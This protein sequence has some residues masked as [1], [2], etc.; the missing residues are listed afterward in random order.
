MRKESKAVYKQVFK[1]YGNVKGM[2]LGVFTKIFENIVAKALVP[3]LFSKIIVLTIN[4]EFIV[5]NN[6]FKTAIALLISSA[7]LG[8]VGNFTFVKSSDRRYRSIV[9]AFHSKML[10]K[11]L[12]F[13]NNIG[14]GKLSSFFR[15]HLDGSIKAA[16]LLRGEILSTLS[17]LLLPTIVFLFYD[18]AI[19]FIFLIVALCD[20]V[21]TNYIASKVKKL[22]KEALVVY[23]D[24][25]SEVNDQINNIE[26][27][28]SSG[29][30][31]DFQSK[32]GILAH[33]EEVL[34]SKRHS[35]E[36]VGEAIKAI[37]ISSALLLILYIIITQPHFSSLEASEMSVLSIIFL[38]QFNISALNFPDLYKI[39]HECIDR[40]YFTL[41]IL[42]KKWEDEFEG[43]KNFPFKAD[44]LFNNVSFNYSLENGDVE[45]FKELSVHIE[46][47]EK[48]A[49]VGKSGSGK[50][51]FA[52]LL[53]RF[54]T[55]DK[56]SILIGNSKIENL[57]IQSLRKSISYV[58]AHPILLNRTIKENLLL[59]N[60]EATE[61]DVITACK[62]SKAYDFIIEL[63]DGFSTV[64]GKNGGRLSSGQRQRISIARALLKFDAEIF[65]FDEVTSALD[66]NNI[67]IIIKN[68][69]KTLNDK[70]IIL[71]T[72]NKQVAK[73]M[74]RII[75]IEQF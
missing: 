10:S 39:Y 67:K 5:V 64:V 53:L 75:N 63:E 47:G 3:V 18:Y 15:D 57:D 8:A 11:N 72:H 45:V 13:Y 14:S 52:R 33:T 50:S 31:A 59:F 28:K 41:P 16:R 4:S 62:Q 73:K 1:Y 54:T 43:V 12:N 66:Y 58:P 40:V 7:I 19:S 49:I 17:S 37:F 38:I 9:L 44:I 27:L 51:T 68:I 25:T 70:T 29:D 21:L 23:K 56:G 32:V 30:T 36:S 22:R 48:I 61:Q 46:H 55:A 74:N 20:I 34:F 35:Y 2:W 71:I 65:I 24:L 42:S 60:Q 26:V 69:L 6:H